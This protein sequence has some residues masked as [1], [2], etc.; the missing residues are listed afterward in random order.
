MADGTLKPLG[1][2][3]VK[4]DSCGTAAVTVERAMRVVVLA[5]AWVPPSLSFVASPALAALELLATAA[6][7]VCTS[8]LAAGS[9]VGPGAVWKLSASCPSSDW[10]SLATS[11]HDDS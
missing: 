9:A 10:S 5:V 4:A 7:G 3:K 6:A 1:T 8:G 11:S 2:V